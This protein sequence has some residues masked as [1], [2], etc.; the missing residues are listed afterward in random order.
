M[1]ES[2]GV[3][4][5][6]LEGEPASHISDGKDQRKL[7]AAESDSPNTIQGGSSVEGMEPAA[8]H[9]QEKLVV[10]KSRTRSVVPYP[11]WIILNAVDIGV[12]NGLVLAT[13]FDSFF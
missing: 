5:E 7:S 8:G 9:H 1:L 2:Y 3:K 12:I 4:I 10:G 11:I 13:R 6:D